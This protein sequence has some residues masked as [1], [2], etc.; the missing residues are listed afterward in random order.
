M[1]R[2][3][4]LI[5]Y[6]HIQTPSLTPLE[7]QRKESQKNWSAMPTLRIVVLGDGGVGKSCV[8][9]VA[10]DISLSFP[11]LNDQYSFNGPFL[12]LFIL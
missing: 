3:S 2:A 11:F 4:L 9:Y 12:F 1:S 10:I 5:L 6:S 7:S 8:T